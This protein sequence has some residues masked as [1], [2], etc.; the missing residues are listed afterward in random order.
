MNDLLQWFQ[1]QDSTTQVLLAFW[2]SWCV[3][4]LLVGAM[5]F[6]AWL[7]RV[8]RRPENGQFA[9]MP[10]SD[11]P[12][13]PHPPKNVTAYGECPYCE[14][15][16]CADVKYYFHKDSE[17]GG[18][19]PRCENHFSCKVKPH[20][21]LYAFTDYKRTEYKPKDMSERYAEMK[22]R[23]AQKEGVNYMHH[24]N[25][26]DPPPVPK[27]WPDGFKYD[28]PLK[29][30]DGD[31]LEVSATM[32]TP[33]TAKVKKMVFEEPSGKRITV[34]GP[35]HI[36]E[37]DESGEEEEDTPHNMIVVAN[38]NQYVLR[39][40]ESACF[41]NGTI[42][43][44]SGDDE[45]ETAPTVREAAEAFMLS[46]RDWGAISLGKTPED[47]CVDDVSLNDWMESVIPLME[48]LREA[49]DAEE[50]KIEQMAARIYEAVI[51][52]SP[53]GDE[54]TGE[55]FLREAKQAAYKAARAFYIKEEKPNED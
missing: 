22:A 14:K 7:V 31:T 49:L 34:E 20:N 1:R 26:S 33:F 46:V 47:L 8:S 43:W 55:E 21:G 42:S 10:W 50:D 38:G 11:P 54:A 17:W 15:G 32:E 39:P 28:G 2:G 44:R 6:L 24:P 36:F 16:I 41:E 37:D 18:Q 40:G 23:L 3:I 13:T 52:Y 45:D 4:A 30:E 27:D 53:G 5:S 48:D 25:P 51:D 12:P 29:F 9:S 35:P 19:C